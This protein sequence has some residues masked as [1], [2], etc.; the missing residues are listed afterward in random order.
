MP[1]S[2]EK[3]VTVSSMTIIIMN[4]SYSKEHIPILTNKAAL[5]H[6][7]SV[8][9][10]TKLMRSI[11]FEICAGLK[12]YEVSTTE[13][14]EVGEKV[15][16]TPPSSYLSQCSAQTGERCQFPF[17]LKGEKEVQWSCVGE[18]GQCSPGSNDATSSWTTDSKLRFFHSQRN[19]HK[20]V[21]CDLSGMPCNLHG[22]IFVGFSLGAFAGKNPF[23]CF[24][25]LLNDN[26]K[27]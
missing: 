13:E 22:V 10:V 20:C 26:V 16:V 11:H 6:L 2:N 4:A 19:F 9:K 12:S 14:G 15:Q 3:L 17:G 24:A 27:V 23:S 8:Q 18:E 7:A 1:A 25:A 5:S 21:D